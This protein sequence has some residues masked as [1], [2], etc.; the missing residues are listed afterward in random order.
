M[1]VYVCVCV[2]MDARARV[3]VCVYVYVY[4]CVWMRACVCRA[5]ARR[6]CG[7]GVIA[8]GDRVQFWVARHARGHLRAHAR[9]EETAAVAAQGA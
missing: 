1:C 4:V 2:C 6:R 5:Y 7:D 8:V 9:E 3:C